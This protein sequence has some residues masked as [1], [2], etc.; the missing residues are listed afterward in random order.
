MPWKGVG[1]GGS[2]GSCG[3]F[4]FGSSGGGSG[5]FGSCGGGGGGVG[6]GVGGGCGFGGVCFFGSDGGTQLGSIGGGFGSA[7]G[8]QLGSIGGGFF[9]GGF[10][11]GL[12]FFG[13]DGGTQLG[14]N[15]FSCAK[16]GQR[17]TISV[18]SENFAKPKSSTGASRFL[19][20][21]SSIIDGESDQPSPR[22]DHVSSEAPNLKVVDY[23]DHEGGLSLWTQIRAEACRHPGFTQLW[24]FPGGGGFEPR[25]DQSGEK[26]GA[27]E[28]KILHPLL[29]NGLKFP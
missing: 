25:S 5:F 24:G 11:G 3:G 22:R 7:G 16:V 9:I 12:C 26:I 18:N 8:I 6:V 19:F 21:P 4:L 27:G 20:L 2:L 13:F 28:S 1:F 14:S 10:G 29:E 15:G 23:E 17:R